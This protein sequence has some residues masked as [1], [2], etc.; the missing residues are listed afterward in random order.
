MNRGFIVTIINIII[1]DL[2]PTNK[3]TSTEI[4]IYKLL[5]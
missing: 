4:K 3:P 1:V 5:D 2:A